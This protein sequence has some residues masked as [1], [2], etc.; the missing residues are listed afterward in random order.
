MRHMLS[1]RDVHREILAGLAA[2]AMTGAAGADPASPAL[3]DVSKQA[4]IA[5]GAFVP[6]AVIDGDM[7]DDAYLALVARQAA[8][9]GGE[10]GT[11]PAR[12]WSNPEKPDF[13]A[14]DAELNFAEKLKVPYYGWL[15]WNEYLPDWLK[16]ASTSEVSD[17]MERH[18]QTILTR[19][20]GRVRYWEPVNEP[21][22]PD[23][24]VPGGLRDGPYTQA[25]GERYIDWAFHKARDL[26][27]DARL[28]L[29]EAHLERDDRFGRIQRPAFLALLD[30][31]LERGVPI[32]AVGLQGHIAPYT[33]YSSTGVQE[34]IGHIKEK[35][36]GVVISEFDVDDR[37]FPDDPAARDQA[38]AKA[39]KQFLDDVFGIKKPEVLLCF[40]LSDRYSWLK[41]D[42]QMK[43]AQPN[44]TPRPLPFDDAFMPKPLEGVI[45]DALR[46]AA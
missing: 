46:K 10:H 40:G 14:F 15:F 19:S 24:G 27:P 34:V 39:G 18:V 6:A 7:K 1:R 3:K 5:F 21:I 44:R 8:I 20:K 12:V 41:F 2:A 30:R 29:N 22:W 38:V 35:G 13:W 37:S 26:A 31:L 33:G 43:Q 25:M 16:R 23:H 28:I 11:A 36:L 9:V 32:D 42:A 4:G 45:R 17:F